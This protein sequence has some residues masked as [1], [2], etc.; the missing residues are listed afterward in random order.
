MAACTLFII[1]YKLQQIINEMHYEEQE[2]QFCA[3]L[4]KKCKSI[5]LFQ[6]MLWFIG[7]W[8]TVIS[9]ENIKKVIF[10]FQTL[11]SSK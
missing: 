11:I 5:T 3:D 2:E 6:K 1:D 7:V 10:Q 8:V 9:N 4:S